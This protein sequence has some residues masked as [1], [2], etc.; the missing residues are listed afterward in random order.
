MTRKRLFSNITLAVGLVAL[1][2]GCASSP[3]F[4][5]QDKALAGTHWKAPVP[6]SGGPAIEDARTWWQAWNDPALFGLIQKALNANTDVR[7]ALADMKAAAALSDAATADLFPTASLSG[8]ASRQRRSGTTTESYGLQAGVSWS[9]SLVGGNIA[10]RRAAAREAM[11]SALSVEDT[12]IAVASEV[13]QNYV[14]WRLARVKTASARRALKNYEQV[15][16][17]ASWRLKAGLATQTEVDQA[18]SER[19]SAAAKIPSY[20]AS[21]TKY[22]N[23]LARLC[24]MNV[25]DI[26]DPQ[27]ETIP[28][29]PAS[30]AVL[31]PAQTLQQRPDMRAAEYAV[32]AASDRLYEARSQWFPTLKITG[33]LGT[34][35]ATIGALG[36]SGTGIAALVGAL[37]MP[38]WN[39]NEQVLA[40]KQKETALEKAQISYT[41]TLVKALEE[42]ENALTGI[43][44]AQKR[45]ENLSQALAS[46]ESAAALALA[47]YEAGLEDYQTVLSTER[48]VIS[49]RETLEEN[50]ADLAT[51]YVKLFTALGGGYKTPQSDSNS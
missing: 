3:L 51:Q 46:A 12:K 19:N 13:A 28:T 34:Q 7:T 11:A 2:A 18:R 8:D 22:K 42:T 14:N 33:N 25:S 30:L 5:E 6:V 35:A 16:E 29:S 48:S 47:Q 39:W 1:L 44:A 45:Q 36:A 31:I 21:Q 43:S 37:S 50:K 9:F 32:L 4:S 24:V 40:G 17:I 27:E 20:E 49:S 26:V 10:A 38:L 15:L 41:A 23:A